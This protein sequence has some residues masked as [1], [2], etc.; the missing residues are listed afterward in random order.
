MFESEFADG[1]RLRFCA[2]LALWWLLT[3]A[4]SA[5]D[6]NDLKVLDDFRKGLDNPELLEWPVNGDD[7]CGPPKWPHVYCSGDR[8]AQIQVQG[9]GLKGLLPL[10][11]NQLSM[12]SNIGLQRNGFYGALPSFS[13][14]SE[15]R[16]AYLDNNNFD[17]IPPG[18]FDGLSSLQVL[19]LDYNPLNK[20]SGWSLPPELATS[21]ELTNLSLIN[22]NLVGP[23]PGYLGELPSL[24]V[25]K[26]SYNR[27]SGEIPASFNQ[28]M[29]QILWLNDQDGGGMSGTLDV[30]PSMLSLTQLWLH[31]NRF[32]G[33]IPENIGALSSLKDLNLNQNQLVG[34]IPESLARMELEKL[35]LNNNLF[36]GPIPKFKSVNVSCDSNYFCLPDPG[37]QCAPQ[38]NALLGFVA[39]VNYPENLVNQ[40]TGNDPCEGP[41]FGLSCN[42]MSKVS[43]INLP[44]HNLSG[45]LSP[46]V[47]DLDSLLEI[48]LAGNQLHGQVPE[49]YTELKSL[50]LLD[51]SGNSLQPPLPKFRNSIK[52]VIEGNP[53]LVNQKM[54]RPGPSAAPSPDSSPSPTNRTSTS[55]PL[56]TNSKG[57]KTPLK[58]SNSG[59]A[60]TQVQPQ[61]RRNRHYKLILVGFSVL[62]IVL[63]VILLSVYCCWKGKKKASVEAPSSIVVHPRDPS[64]PENQVKV[65]VSDHTNMS[66]FTHSSGSRHSTGTENSH[67]VEGGNIIISVQVLSKVT[68]NFSPEN[69]LGR[70]GFGTVYKGELY[71]GTKIAVK[72]MEA[73]PAS[74]KALDEFQCEIAVLSKVR[75]RHLV[76]L[77]GYSIES[78]ERLLVYEYM[79]QGA[80]SRHL[81]HWEANGLEPLSWKKRFT[82]ALDVAK[83][84]EYL[85][86]LAGQIFIHRD[87]KSS[88]ILL[89]DDF[90]AKVSDFGLVK[91]APDGERSVTTRLAGTF[92]YLAPEY[93][94]MGKITTK[95][96]VF[97]YGVVLMEL[98][99]G[100]TALDE[101]RPEESRYLAEWFWRIKSSKEKLTKAL[102]GAVEA[103]EETLESISIVADLASLCTARE[104]NH[105]PDMGHVVNALTPLVEKWKPTNDESDSPFGIDFGL[106][107][108]QMLKVWQETEKNE[109]G[110][111]T[112]LDD[113]SGSIPARPTGFAESFTSADGR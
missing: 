38:V 31:G 64:D 94:V 97:S 9:L 75:H 63:L 54:P 57:S 72:R 101:S 76:S 58:G 70:G 86:S 36:T 92:G 43:I 8:I 14:L 100:L 30:I 11:F 53:L 28:S 49:N 5:T 16:F 112:T 45:T 39:A 67:M 3:V 35:D 87:L 33:T 55:D 82:I 90:R 111:T 71:D 105:R 2:S 89:G 23:L 95:V 47:A 65:V 79:P 62:M 44:R 110:S 93:A 32:S 73:G 1:K 52:V 22:C 77:L 84:M 91:L 109:S 66:L 18:F 4:Y 56:P 107:L 27:L 108:P 59:P 74:S 41:W 106:P 50:R 6:P 104:P 40:W 69:E 88:N 99:T 42:S 61:M 13:G 98:L 102:D 103:N 46:S 60:P 7:P 48:R 37:I 51:L 80:L 19:A 12:L 24:T 68:K 83:G 15:L 17:T 78:N 20:T 25:L 34:P 85:H 26:L 81:F 10:N 29:T 96:D 113:S 21:A